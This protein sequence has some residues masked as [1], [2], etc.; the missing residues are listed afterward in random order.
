VW[1]WPLLFVVIAAAFI[2]SAFT[3]PDQGFAPVPFIVG[4]V[5]AAIGI[6]PMLIGLPILPS[7]GRAADRGEPSVK[8]S[9]ALQLFFIALGGVGGYFLWGALV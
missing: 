2:F 6:G 8:G 1:C 3:A 7:P 5:M 9:L 4:I